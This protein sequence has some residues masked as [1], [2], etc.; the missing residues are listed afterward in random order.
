MKKCRCFQNSWTTFFKDLSYI[1]KF[2]SFIVLYFQIKLF[3]CKELHCQICLP[4]LE[5]LTAP[6][7][8]S[9]KK[10]SIEASKYIKI[11]KL[12][13][14]QIL[15]RNAKSAARWNSA[16]K[17]SIFIMSRRGSSGRWAGGRSQIRAHKKHKLNEEGARGRINT[18]CRVGKK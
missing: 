5:A 15:W 4:R 13:E 8:L 1:S 18:R 11:W 10:Y 14:M 7:S 6:L 3:Y 16:K 2:L 12:L 17:G 9:D